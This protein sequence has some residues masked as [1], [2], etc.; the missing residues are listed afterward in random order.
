M[1]WYQRLVRTSVCLWFLC[2]AGLS[3]QEFNHNY[4]GFVEPSRVWDVSPP[5]SGHIQAIRF[6]EGQLVSEGD[7]LVE[8]NPRLAQLKM[9]LAQ[10]GLARAQAALKDSLADLE[11]HKKLRE[12][13][14]VALSVFAD[15]ELATE[16]AR[17]DLLSAELE[18]ELAETVLGLHVLTAPSN[19]MVSAPMINEGSN[20]NAELSGPIATVSLLD[21]IRVRMNLSLERALRRLEVGKFDLEAV[22][23]ARMT[24]TLPGGHVYKHKGRII[25]ITPDFD[26]ETGQAS[27]VLEFPNPSNLLRPGIPVA[28]SIEPN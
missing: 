21:P 26:T 22:R 20:Y 23:A 17:I 9:E 12:R 6:T 7:V 10:A 3:A 28:V 8:L 14:A 11:R 18:V 16:F 25:A 15:V 5:V 1:G 24:L 4:N 2:A 13:D 27:A 19:G